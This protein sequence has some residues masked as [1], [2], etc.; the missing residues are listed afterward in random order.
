MR[1]L[2]Q[3]VTSGVV[4][5]DGNVVGQIGLGAVLMV[6]IGKGDTP[7]TVDKMADKI[8]SMR[9]FSDKDLRFQ[10]TIWM[11]SDDWASR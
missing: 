1:V 7:P 2:L 4:E 6:G 8:V 3:R 11:D 10:V 5:I 9:I